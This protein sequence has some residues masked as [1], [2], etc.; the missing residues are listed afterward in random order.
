MTGASSKGYWRLSRT[1]AT[2]TGMTNDWLRTQGLLRILL[3]STLTNRQ[4]QEPQ[5]LWTFYIL[6]TEVEQAFKELKQ[7][8]AVRPIYHQKESRIEA[9]IF[10]AFL[11]Y[12]LQVTLKAKLRPLAC[13][14]TPRE[15]LAKFK[16]M[17]MLR[18]HP[19]H[20]RARTGVL[21]LHPPSPNTACCSSNSG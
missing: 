5:R 6:L 12:C 18:V 16:T 21:A 19:H 17:K 3:C 1:L 7:D 20:R 4:A 11:A 2:Q 9:H 13:G 15:V 14:I 10:V 8:L